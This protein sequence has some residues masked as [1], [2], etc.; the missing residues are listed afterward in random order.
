MV[1]A[2]QKA[3]KPSNT[4]CSRLRCAAYNDPNCKDEESLCGFDSGC[5]R[6]LWKW[7]SEA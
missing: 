2:V 4:D 1:L 7:T 3:R 6:Q 5:D